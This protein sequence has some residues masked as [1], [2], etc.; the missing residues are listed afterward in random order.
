MIYDEQGKL[1]ACEPD[2][3]IPRRLASVPA[4]LR[5]C[6]LVPSIRPVPTLTL[7]QINEQ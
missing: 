6:L 1:K 5:I 7:V 4:A 3:R 2:E